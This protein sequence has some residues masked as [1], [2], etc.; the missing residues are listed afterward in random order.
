MA[1][2]GFD[3]PII[4][5]T[6]PHDGPPGFPIGGPG[7]GTGFTAI[8]GGTAT[9]GGRKA[10]TNG[11]GWWVKAVVLVLIEDAK[12]DAARYRCWSSSRWRCCRESE[13]RGLVAPS[14]GGNGGVG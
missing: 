9:M 8:V 12:R 10:F 4:P 13:S 6:R 3:P 5:G 1:T 7:C 2:L 14:V 11:G